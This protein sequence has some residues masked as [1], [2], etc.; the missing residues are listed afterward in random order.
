MVDA[1]PNGSDERRTFAVARVDSRLT[2]R[3]GTKIG[4]SGLASC[5][6]AAVEG[7]L[8]LRKMSSRGFA[9]SA[10]RQSSVHIRYNNDNNNNDNE[11]SIVSIHFCLQQ[12][13]NAFAAQGMCANFVSKHYPD[14][15]LP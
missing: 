3:T 11:I 10:D 12:P 6:G 8:K 1:R 14:P 5:S 15:A 2:F 7:L 9:S 13:S 4:T